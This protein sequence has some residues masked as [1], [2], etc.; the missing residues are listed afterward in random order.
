MGVGGRIPRGVERGRQFEIEVDGRPVPV[1][2]GETLAAALAAFG[3]RTLRHTNRQDAPRGIF[4]GM[5]ICFDCAMTVNG[6]PNVRSCVTSVEPGMKVL[7]Q[8]ESRW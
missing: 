4:C 1:H 2:E 3:V 8:R 5:G 7:T 6:V